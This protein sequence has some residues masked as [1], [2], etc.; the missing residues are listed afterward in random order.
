MADGV[1]RLDL[2]GGELRI[3]SLNAA[4]FGIPGEPD[5]AAIPAETLV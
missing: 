1:P 5:L 3:G 2:R 4:P